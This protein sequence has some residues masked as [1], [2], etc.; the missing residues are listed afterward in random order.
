MKKPSKPQS[1]LSRYSKFAA[2]IPIVFLFWALSLYLSNSKPVPSPTLTPSSPNINL[3]EKRALELV[4]TRKDVQDYMNKIPNAQIA[5]DHFDEETNSYVIHVFEVKNG[6]TNTFNWY[7]VNK[8]TG[9]ITA[10]F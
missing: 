10:E 8:L 3:D 6:H 9:T 1:T 4:K 7:D 2:L 5:I